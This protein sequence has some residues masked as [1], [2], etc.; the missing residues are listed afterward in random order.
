MITSKDFDRSILISHLHDQFWSQEYYL[1]ANRVRQWKAT[2]GSGWAGDLFRQ[3]DEI[4]SVLTEEV[5]EAFETNAARRLIKSYFRKTQQFCSRG[6][7]ERG[8]LSEHLAMPQRL[9][10]LFEMI[11]PFEYARKPDYNREMFEFYDDLH[12]CQLIRPAR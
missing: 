1:A 7:L 3:M 10:M 2:K 8:D 12:Q 9:S 6:F 5:P 11:E 4:G